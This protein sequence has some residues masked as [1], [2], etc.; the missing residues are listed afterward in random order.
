MTLMDRFAQT[1]KPVAEA[2]WGRGELAERERER[3]PGGAS[4]RVKAPAVGDLKRK[5][6]IQRRAKKTL[7]NILDSGSL[8]ST[9]HSMFGA[10]AT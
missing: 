1:P 3:A 9:S 5:K 8:E 4:E 10:E 6:N 2:G 7:L